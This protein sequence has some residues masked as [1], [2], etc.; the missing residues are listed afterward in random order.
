M[1]TMLTKKN[2]SFKSYFLTSE[3]SMVIFFVASS[4]NDVPSPPSLQKGTCEIIF[5]NILIAIVPS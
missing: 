4:M 5:H 3:Q 1:K 2:P